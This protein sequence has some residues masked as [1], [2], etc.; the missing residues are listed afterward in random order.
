MVV[1]KSR[2]SYLNDVLGMLKCLNPAISHCFLSEKWLN[3]N[4]SMRQN[5]SHRTLIF[6][7]GSAVGIEGQDLEKIPSPISLPYSVNLCP[8]C[9]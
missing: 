3:K 9:Y 8:T 6:G 4:D 5:F 1:E 2:A 7:G